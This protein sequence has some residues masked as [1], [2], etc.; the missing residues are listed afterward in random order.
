MSKRTTTKHENKRI[1]HKKARAATHQALEGGY[2]RR[3][4][5]IGWGDKL[6][7]PPVLDERGPGIRRKKNK[8]RWCKGQVG[9]EH[10]WVKY[11]KYYGSTP[12]TKTRC[13]RCRKEVWGA[14]PVDAM[15]RVDS[16]SSHWATVNIWRRLAGKYCLCDKCDAEVRAFVEGEKNTLDNP[17]GNQ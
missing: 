12:Y 9:K 6:E 1:G 3:V 8:R 7:Q 17:S 10:V 15:V 13:E 4:Y 11:V 2:T 5:G 16:T 14:S